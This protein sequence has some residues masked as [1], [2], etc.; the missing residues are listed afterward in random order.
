MEFLCL[1]FCF[2]LLL[3]SNNS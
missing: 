2:L 1:V 3:S